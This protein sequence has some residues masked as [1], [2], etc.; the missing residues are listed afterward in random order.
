MALVEAGK[1]YRL[2]GA[3]NIP[4]MENFKKPF[5]GDVAYHMRN[6]KHGIFEYDWMNFCDFFG[7]KLSKCLK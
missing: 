1:V 7:A 6:G 3:K 5:L 2:F 4:S